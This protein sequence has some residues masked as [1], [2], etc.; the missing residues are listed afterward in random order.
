M[1]DSVLQL[2]VDRRYLATLLKYYQERGVHIRSKSELG[3][4]VFEELYH[5]LVDNSLVE[6]VTFSDDAS[7]YINKY[8]SEE[9]GL[10]PGGRG[11]TNLRLNV[12]DQEQSQTEMVKVT[13]EF[14]TGL[15]K[16]KGEPKSAERV[17][18]DTSPIVSTPEQVKRAKDQAE[19]SEGLEVESEEDFEDYENG[20][21]E[22][23]S[24]L[25]SIPDKSTASDET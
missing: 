4:K 25:D 23:L 24:E 15:E 22:A 11:L 13:K 20:Q 8:F 14:F 10:N 18:T 21:I 9:G 12:L 3:R 17:V 7:S 6:P 19:G 16:K 5:I 2:R 1:N